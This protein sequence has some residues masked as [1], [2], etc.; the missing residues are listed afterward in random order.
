M[1]KITYAISESQNF[2]LA[3][4]LSFQSNIYFDISTQIILFS[5]Y[6]KFTQNIS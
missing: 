3:F 5:N 1:S 4:D 6:F 2:S